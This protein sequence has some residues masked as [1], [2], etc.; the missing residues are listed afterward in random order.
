MAAT[1]RHLSVPHK[2]RTEQD[3]NPEVLR[4][5][6]Q[7]DRRSRLLRIHTTILT[8]QG[9]PQQLADD[10]TP[11]R[12]W[13]LSDGTDIWLEQKGPGGVLSAEQLDWHAWARETG[14]HIYTV[15]DGADVV[16]AAN[17]ARRNR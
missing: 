5:C 10:G 1:R 12:L 4:A 13:L 16:R 14:R 17:E 6:R 9:H 7:V 2:F 8:A 11:D 3:T 15:W